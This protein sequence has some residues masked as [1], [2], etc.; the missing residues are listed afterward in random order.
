MAKRHKKMDGETKKKTGEPQYERA[1]AEEEIQIA[2][3]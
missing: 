1:D 2:F 3:C